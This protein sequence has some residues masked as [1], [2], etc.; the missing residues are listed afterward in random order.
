V[1]VAPEL[2]VVY[3]ILAVG[4]LVLKPTE[5]VSSAL[6]RPV[7]KSSAADIKPIAPIEL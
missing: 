6:T 3:V 2:L 7:A 4:T 5:I 1:D